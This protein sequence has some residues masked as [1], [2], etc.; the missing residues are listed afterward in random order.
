MCG[1]LPTPHPLVRFDVV[2][3]DRDVIVR[4]GTD[5]SADATVAAATTFVQRTGGWVI[6]EGIEDQRILTAVCNTEDPSNLPWILAGQGYLLG[7]PSPTPVPINTRLDAFAHDWADP[8]SSPLPTLPKK[9][10]NL[11]AS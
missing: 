9:P 1:P 8:Q 2:K 5:P 4:L 10:S 3:I 11:P 6:A 7:R